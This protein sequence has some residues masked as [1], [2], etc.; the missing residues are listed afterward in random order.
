MRWNG[1]LRLG[2]LLVE[3][4]PLGLGLYMAHRPLSATAFTMWQFVEPQICHFITRD[5][6]PVLVRSSIFRRSSKTFY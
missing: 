5:I 1:M 2:H 4:I 6:V 3:L